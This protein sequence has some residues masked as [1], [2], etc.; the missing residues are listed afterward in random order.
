MRE[1]NA[2]VCPARVC[3]A[4]VCPRLSC[5]A[6]P[7]A[8]LRSRDVCAHRGTRAEGRAAPTPA[9]TRALD[10]GRLTR[11]T[12][13]TDLVHDGRGPEEARREGV[14]EEVAEPGG[15]EEARSAR[16]GQVS[17]RGEGHAQS[18][19]GAPHALGPGR[20]ARTVSLH[21]ER[22][23]LGP[24]SGGSSARLGAREQCA[25][26]HLSSTASSCLAVSVCTLCLC[27]VAGTHLSSTASTAAAPAPRECPH[28]TRPYPACAASA[29]R[30][31]GPASSHRLSAACAHAHIHAVS[32]HV[33]HST[34]TRST[35]TCST[36]T[37]STHT[38]STH[39][40]STHTCCGVALRRRLPQALRRLRLRCQCGRS[41]LSARS[42]RPS[43]SPM[44]P[45]MPSP[46]AA[47]V[48]VPAHEEME[49]MA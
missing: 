16:L 47:Y 13:P 26:T 27:A 46:R 40:C 24:G 45:I 32:V 25:G 34:H 31:A 6:C 8:S 1:A 29:A 41:M 14:G 49:E 4:R 23:A 37:C 12:G 5:S 10:A 33:Q 19:G 48:S 20:W 44:R 7:H 28:S 38:C 17:R 36:H 43:E 18:P 42:S 30:A 39:T 11:S 2:R 15:E 9:R 22:D 35:H 21:P 3:P